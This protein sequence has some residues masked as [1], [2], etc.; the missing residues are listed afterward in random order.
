MKP[1]HRISAPVIDLA[2]ESRSRALGTMLF[3]CLLGFGPLAMSAAM[4]QELQ[5]IA[6]AYQDHRDAID[7]VLVEY[8]ESL[9]FLADPRL[10]FERRRLIFPVTESVIV[11]SQGEKTYLEKETQTKP[12]GEL[13]KLIQQ[14]KPNIRLDEV[15]YEDVQKWL[16]SLPVQS[17]R[18]ILVYDGSVLREKSPI[19]TYDNTPIYIVREFERTGA[20]LFPSSYLRYVGYGFEDPGATEKNENAHRFAALLPLAT[21]I[22]NDE[23]DGQTCV[24]VDIPQAA[25]GSGGMKLWLDPQLGF[26]LR[27]RQYFAS[28][29]TVAVESEFRDFTNVIADTWLPRNVVR[30]FAGNAELPNPYEISVQVSRIEVNQPSHESY[31]EHRPPPG[32]QVVDETLTQLDEQGNPVGDRG[33]VNY[34]QPMDEKDLEKVIREAQRYQKRAEGTDG[35]TFRWR[36][37][38]IVANL[39]LLA[40]LVVV[41]WWRRGPAA[42]K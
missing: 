24:V 28:D 11:V 19:E 20:L 33:S 15:T 9:K 13:L 40:M 21:V 22:G 7:S 30:R 27:K 29:G 42:E 26:A 6:T 25:T 2:G 16:P 32:S 39:A 41:F 23:V 35:R 36:M 12:V 37:Q 18:Q 17:T 4:G 34:V 5:E 14:E 3:L 10:L 1:R 31:F 8:E 38:M